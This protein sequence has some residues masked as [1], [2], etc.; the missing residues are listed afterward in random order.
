MVA[1]ALAKARA[2]K[3]DKSVWQFLNDCLVQIESVFAFFPPSFHDLN[4][5]VLV[6]LTLFQECGSGSAGATGELDFIRVR[7]RRIVI[8]FCAAK[9]RPRKTETAKKAEASFGL[10]IDYATGEMKDNSSRDARSYGLQGFEELEALVRDQLSELDGMLDSSWA[11]VLNEWYDEEKNGIEKSRVQALER[12]C[13]IDS[14]AKDNARVGVKNVGDMLMGGASAMS[15]DEYEATFFASVRRKDIDELR[16]ML[17][18]DYGEGF[19]H[20]CLTQY[21]GDTAALIEGIFG[22][23][24]PV[25]LEV[26][27]KKMTLADAMEVGRAA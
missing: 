19:L 24:L 2:N 12:L 7:C 5:D 13:G 1:Q 8:R 26:L 17:G 10:G 15:A 4:D 22:Q 21:Q 9:Y 25:A 3:S 23:A 11:V 27:D 6:Y 16:D 18:D 14:A 20:L